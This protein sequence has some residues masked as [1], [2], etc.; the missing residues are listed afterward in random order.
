M[1]NLYILALSLLVIFNTAQAQR[2]D[3]DNTS[4]WFLGL[5]LGGTWSTTDV[6]D[7]LYAGWGLTLGKS[8]NYDYG[9]K[10]TFD[11]RARYL[12]GKWYGQDL[13]KTSLADYNPDNVVDPA[14][15]PLMSYKDSGIV[16]NFQADVHRLGFELVLH[17]NGIRERSGWD[18]YI[19]GGVGFTWYQTY[20]DLYSNDTIGGNY[21]YAADN[22]SKTEISDIIDG[23][24]DSPLVGSASNKFS[25]D[26]MPS[27]GVGLGYQIGKRT[28]FGI[29]HKTTFTLNDHFDGYVD[30][31]S[32]IKND[33][34]HY[35]SLYLQFRFKVRG[36]TSV[37]DNN[38]DNIN[39]YTGNSNCDLPN[40]VF[41]NPTTNDQLSVGQTFVVS[42]NLTNVINRDNITFL[43]NGS[44]N[45]NFVYNPS[46]GRFEST[47]VLMNGSNTFEIKAT[48]TCGNASNSIS[49]SYQ[50]CINPIINW[51]SP[52]VNNSTV[53]TANFNLSA[54][55]QTS[56]NG[57]GITLSQNGRAIT[58]VN[59]N[60][61]T[62]ALTSAVTLTSGANVFVLSVAN[63]CGTATETITINF[64]SCVNPT[65][66]LTAPTV[67]NLAV[68]SAS[69]NLSALI[70]NSTN[71][72]GVSLSQNGRAITNFSFNNATGSLSSN[73]TLNQGM[74]TFVI[75]VVNACGTDTETITVN[76]QNC[77]SPT[78]NWS[79]PAANNTTVTSANFNLSALVQNSNNGQGITLVKNGV[80]ITNFS[81][82]NATGALTSN[83]TL[84]P[85]ANVFVIT[86]T[87]ACGTATETIT[88]NYQNCVAPTVSF[89]T[90]AANNT[91][92]TS[93]NFNLSALVQNSNNGQGITLVKNGA[94][95]TNFSFNNVTGALTS[96]VTLVP[97]AN[98]FV[99]TVTS[100]CG[101]ATET[102]TVNYQNCVPPTASFVT[103]AAN[104][105]T[106]TS[107]NFNLS[108][109]VQ[110]SN[111]GQGITLTNSGRGIT[112]FSVNNAT[113]ALTSNVTLIPGAN[114]F[115]ITVT[116]A[117]GTATETITVNYQICV[118]P[119]VT[120]IAPASSSIT[121]TSPNY[122]LS[123]V[124]LNSNNGQGLVATQN[125]KLITNGSFNPSNG[126]LTGSVVLYP[127]T[128]VF[129]VSVT[130]NC[131]TATATVTIIYNEE[132]ENNSNPEQKITICHIP[133]GNNGNPQTIEIPL[134]A[135]P[136]H[137][138]HGD[139]LGPCV[140]EEP[141]E[142]DNSNQPEQ[143]ITICHIPPGN[144]GNPQ[145][146][147]IPLSAWPAHQAHGDVLGPCVIEEPI[148]EDNSNQP[149]QKI[150]ICHIPPGNN[151][152]PQTI[153]IPLSAWPAHQ[154]HGDVLGPCAEEPAGNNNDGQGNSQNNG[155][156]NGSGLGGV[157]NVGGGNGQSGGSSNGNSGNNGGTE[158]DGENN[159]NGS[160]NEGGNGSGNKSVEKPK[161]TPVVK[162]KVTPQKGNQPKSDPVKEPL[163]EEE[164]GKEKE[165]P[166]EEV[167]APPPIKGKGGK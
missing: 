67:N 102:I 51:S 64:Q 31:S 23:V 24:Y 61:T 28:T 133:P 4:K 103:P 84:V 10:I 120:F 128:N 43:F 125:G 132:E 74:N 54:L 20:G 87:N 136:A 8:F 11:L 126:S 91:T 93:A 165:V 19:F 52:S 142:E 148:E 98:V 97:G 55:V 157:G 122:N 164:K 140:I 149:E 139:V 6:R 66:T 35:T 137:Q 151:G 14:Q 119:T 80:G 158:S 154:A 109:L 72:Q 89:V 106:V 121:V 47:V 12:R 113:G 78:I 69:F 63:A 48:N 79:S 18:P 73:V 141:I 26:F 143:K 1:K 124:I 56:T 107:A 70:Q 22:Y 135:W 88:V 2:I 30:G 130:T 150:T 27:L 40:I 29:E 161:A 21:S 131:G 13:T 96:N 115:V 68:T 62:D 101:T 160:G 60:G 105:T 34:Y 94:G 32:K 33:L 53:T 76:Y 71:A 153:E 145:T 162:P 45:T 85:G 166:I 144:N 111:N 90:P 167:P 75:T 81:F 123:A 108:A 65:I 39:N 100:A 50:N 5:N 104:N 36:N 155:N 163:K 156:S 46:N 3:Y 86:V 83:V 77:L 99:I 116:N 41:I 16:N 38:V 15:Y 129:V 159:G 82:N 59:F 58:N 7:D 95:I 112:S 57:Q 114:V 152:N 17:A 117:C 118:A 138:A 44:V 147:E 37:P 110:N 127:G 146:I 42:A 9:R 134:S 92:V 25:V 49:V